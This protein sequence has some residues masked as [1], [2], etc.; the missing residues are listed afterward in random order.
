MRYRYLLTVPGSRSINS[1]TSAL[2]PSGYDLM[3]KHEEQVI[4][5]QG[6]ADDSVMMARGNPSNTRMLVVG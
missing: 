4:E 2:D 3:K 6:Y 1:I 5:G